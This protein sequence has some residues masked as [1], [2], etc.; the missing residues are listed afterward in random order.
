M[1]DATP[2]QPGGTPATEVRRIGRYL[3]LEQFAAGGMATVHYGRQLGSEGFSRVVAIKRMHPGLM[4]EAQARA[5]LID[6]G[7]FA[8]RVQ[9]ANVVQTLDVVVEGD[10]VLLVLEHVMGESLDKLLKESVAQRRLVPPG[11]VVAVLAGALRG[12][13]AAHEARGEDGQPLDLVHRDLS[14]HNIMVDA[15]GVPRVADFGIAKARGRVS[16][17]QTGHL[18]GKLAYVAPEQIHGETSRASDLFSMGIVLW[19]CLALRRLFRGDNEAETLAAVL[20]CEVPDVPAAPPE[21][22][23]IARKA[24]ARLPGRRYATALEFAEAL[25]GAWPAA[26]ASEVGAWVRE[27]VSSTLDSRAARIVA[28]EHAT[29]TVPTDTRSHQPGRGRWVPLAGAALALLAVGGGAGVFFS[30]ANRGDTPSPVVA[31]PPLALED[32]GTVPAL[33]VAVPVMPEVDAGPSEPLDD[34]PDAGVATRPGKKR[35]TAKK[36]KP[37]C[38][39]PWTIDS[40]GRKH[41]KLECL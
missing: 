27:L 34:E 30:R 13:H 39:V 25:E 33:A 21:L 37:E 40:N 8:A 26:S 28:L 41:Y 11:V 31:P 22:L 24:L 10:E 20:R 7:R 1:T 23:A 2:T 6:E 14:P 17:T 32:A 29:P 35:P 15:S 16:N 38:A 4:Q 5:A 36:K 18:K 9:H 12:V 3:L 19:E